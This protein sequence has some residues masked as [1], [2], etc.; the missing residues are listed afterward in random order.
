MIKLLTSETK[1]SRMNQVKS[2]EDSIKRRLLIKS[3]QYVLSLVSLDSLII[4]ILTRE[5]CWDLWQTC[6]KSCHLIEIGNQFQGSV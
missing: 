4:P 6:L 2:V 1:Y 5:I 3:Y